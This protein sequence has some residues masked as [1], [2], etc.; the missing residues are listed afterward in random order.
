MSQ[1]LEVEGAPYVVISCLCPVNLK[2]CLA[3][4]LEVVGPVVQGGPED[5]ATGQPLV[6]REGVLCVLF[7]VLLDVHDAGV[8]QL[9]RCEPAPKAWWW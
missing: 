8:V 9:V 1:S 2:A 7:V 6:G 4:G 3:G 5:V